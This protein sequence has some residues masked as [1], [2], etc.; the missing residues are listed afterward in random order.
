[1]IDARDAASIEAF[2]DDAEDQQ[3]NAE[4]WSSIWYEAF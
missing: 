3:K 4:R 1:M 2:E